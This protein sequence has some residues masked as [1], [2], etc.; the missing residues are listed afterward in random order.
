M[1][2]IKLH[3]RSSLTFKKSGQELLQMYF[4]S[5]ILD[6]ETYS[7]HMFRQ[8]EGNNSLEGHAIVF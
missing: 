1:Q 2:Q 8:I 6:H 4:D 3:V 5:Y 7:F